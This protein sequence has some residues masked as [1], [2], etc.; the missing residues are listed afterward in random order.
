MNKAVPLDNNKIVI[1][2]EQGY[3]M[4]RPSEIVAEITHNNGI[5]CDVKVGGSAVIVI[6]GIL[7]L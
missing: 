4:D 7:F 1:K 5:V 3:I 2:V 6:E